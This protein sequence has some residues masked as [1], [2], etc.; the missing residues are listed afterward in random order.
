MS[1]CKCLTDE[2]FVTA[3]PV[4]SVECTWIINGEIYPLCSR[5]ESPVIDWK[6]IGILIFIT[7]AVKP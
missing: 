1:G 7:F 6:M 2:V 5:V 3:S 4:E